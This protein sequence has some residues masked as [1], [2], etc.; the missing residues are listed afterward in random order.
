MYMYLLAS[1]F[2]PSFISLTCIH[3]F[4]LLIIIILCLILL[5]TCLHAYEI[6]HNSY[7]YYCTEQHTH[8]YI[9]IYMYTHIHVY[10]HTC[11]Q[12]SPNLPDFKKKRER[13]RKVNGR[14]NSTKLL[15]EEIDSDS[16]WT[17]TSSAN[18]TK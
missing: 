9:H 8:T 7:T 3:T 13:K 12:H 2:L 6:L 14:T 1:F 18:D 17:L 15:L 10:T 16:N 5:C 11:T 4:I